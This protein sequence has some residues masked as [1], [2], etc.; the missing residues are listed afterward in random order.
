M[1]LVY[2]FNLHLQCTM[3]SVI[4]QCPCTVSLYSV[5]VQCPCTVSLYG[6]LVRCP[7][8]VS[9]YGV[10][11]GCPCT[12][13]WWAALVGCPCMLSLYNVHHPSIPSMYTFLVSPPYVGAVL[14]RP[15]LKSI[16]SVD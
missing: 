9:L 11:V 10:L 16:C 12:V 6:V 14:N 3:Y 5:L 7:C 13:S 4:V 1:I 15:S 8:M 2:L